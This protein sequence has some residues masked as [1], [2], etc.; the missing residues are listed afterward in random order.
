MVFEE[1]PVER[2]IDHAERTLGPMVT[3]KQALGPEGK[4]DAV[5]VDLMF[6][7]AEAN[8]AEDGTMRAEAE[9]LMTTLDLPG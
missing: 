8:E 4:W 7:Y 1:A 6:L 2:W 5:R 9:Y 3:A